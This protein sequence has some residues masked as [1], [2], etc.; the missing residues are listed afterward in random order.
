MTQN[1]IFN[2]SRFKNLLLKELKENKK[3]LLLR[4]LMLYG[5]LTITFLLAAL[6]YYPTSQNEYNV[7]ALEMAAFIGILFVTG[8]A[9][10]S[11]MMEHI[12]TKTKRISTLILPASSFE[13][14][15]VRW[16]IFVVFFLMFYWIAFY[17]AD[18]TR[19]AIYSA[20]YPE[21][22]LISP[23]PLSD[24]L[25]NPGSE[26][27]YFKARK[28]TLLAFSGYLA[29]QSFFV[30]GSCIWPKNSFIKTFAALFLLFGVYFYFAFL[31]AEQYLS[32]KYISDPFP[33]LVNEG[34]QELVGICILSGIVLF[35]WILAYFRFKESEIIQR[36]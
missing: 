16:L 5:F 6:Q 19:M 31:S 26:Y 28:L 8:C 3:S 22:T 21:N 10:A 34:N 4:W 2:L 36:W 11:L 27:C 17:L 15:I 32:N 1:T 29:I 13:K 9:S 30:L 18:W 12:N 35:N 14:F 24:F 23:L 25:W 33:N 20:A 7:W